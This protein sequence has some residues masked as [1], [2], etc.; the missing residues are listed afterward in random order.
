MFEFAIVL[1]STVAGSLLVW[2]LVVALD[3]GTP[4]PWVRNSYEVASDDRELARLDP[5]T[6]LKLAD[7]LDASVF[8]GDTRLLRIARL[9]AAARAEIERRSCEVLVGTKGSEGKS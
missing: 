6:A 3:A 4:F 1:L 5:T 8:K 9:R 7:R 2:Y